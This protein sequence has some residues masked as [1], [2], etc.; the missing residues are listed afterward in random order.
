MPAVGDRLAAAHGDGGPSG[1]TVTGGEVAAA[2]AACEDG[3][4]P[5]LADSVMLGVTAGTGS[6]LGDGVMVI[7]GLDD[8]S[9]AGDVAAGGGSGPV[10][11]GGR[12]TTALTGD[13]LAISATVTDPAA[14]ASAPV[15]DSET[16]FH[17][18]CRLRFRSRSTTA[19]RSWVSESVSGRPRRRIAAVL[20]RASAAARRRALSA[21]QAAIPARSVLIT[22]PMAVPAIPRYPSA[23]GAITAAPAVA[24]NVGR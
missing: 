21:H 2:D 1:L 13:P 17:G 24:V 4:V 9:G 14:S 5:G 8:G 22:V 18:M 6:R 20:A 19:T 23:S 11:V 16:S 15:Q 7:T 3:S 12:E 10:S